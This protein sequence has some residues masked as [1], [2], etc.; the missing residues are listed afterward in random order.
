MALI[1]RAAATLAGQD[2]LTLG[3]SAGSV[4]VLVLV[5]VMLPVSGL[6]LECL[7]DGCA[8]VNRQP[9]GTCRQRAAQRASPV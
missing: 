8:L 1:S 3:S 2:R 4:L 6:P 9:G 7:A 5:L